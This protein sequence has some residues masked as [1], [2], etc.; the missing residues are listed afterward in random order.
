[1]CWKIKTPS[2]DTSIPASTLVPQTDAGIP[3]SP[4]FGGSQST[5]N[6]KRGRQQLTITR[7][8]SY[9]PTNF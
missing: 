1:M 8:G 2:V 9:N 4:E 5:F 3:E 6:K 7:N